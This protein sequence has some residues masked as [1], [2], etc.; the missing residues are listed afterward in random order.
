MRNKQMKIDVTQTLKQLG[1]EPIMQ[2]VRCAKC[3]EVYAAIHK[4]LSPDARVELAEHQE[5]IE[6]I[7]SDE[8]EPMTLRLVI[9]RALTTPMK[10]DDLTPEK[11]VARF[12]LAMR[13]HNNDE[14]EFT[15][16]E[17]TLIKN[18]IAKLF[19]SPLIV[20]QACLIL[21]PGMK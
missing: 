2:E 12:S 11:G 21:D 6:R 3:V 16:E 18:R 7:V 13:V 19:S 1:G 5:E 9:N 8:P 10:D 4:L 14:V 20:G 15:A 17:L